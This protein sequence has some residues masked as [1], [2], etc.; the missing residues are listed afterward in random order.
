MLSSCVNPAK[1]K[2]NK[3]PPVLSHTLWRSIFIVSCVELCSCKN[4]R[5]CSSRRSIF[6]HRPQVIQ[7]K[8]ACPLIY[9]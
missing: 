9:V 1:M 5:A 6:Y 3:K 4:S 7:E 2:H 8:C